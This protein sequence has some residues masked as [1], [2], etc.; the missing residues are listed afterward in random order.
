MSAID[1]IVE[2]FEHGTVEVR[3]NPICRMQVGGWACGR[4]ATVRRNLWPHWSLFWCAEHAAH[5]DQPGHWLEL[6]EPA[7][8]RRQN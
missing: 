6:E 4:P 8:L 7:F 1:R 5:F 3:A 2:E